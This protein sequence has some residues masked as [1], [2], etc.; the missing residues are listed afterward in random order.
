MKNKINNHTVLLVKKEEAKKGEL[1]NDLTNQRIFKQ[2]GGHD[3]PEDD[4]HA[5]RKYADPV[6]LI[7]KITPEE[8]NSKLNELAE[9]IRHLQAN[10]KLPLLPNSDHDEFDESEE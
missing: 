9:K 10:E 1:W 6:D 2:H 5:V 8:T 3:I 7:P 4:H